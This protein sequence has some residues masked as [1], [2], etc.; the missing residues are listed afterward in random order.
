MVP[1]LLFSFALSLV[2]AARAD[3]ITLDSGAVIEGD[4]A[5]FEFGGDCQISVTD[6]PLLGAI[7]IVPCRRVQ[8][9]VRTGGAEPTKVG[10]VEPAK[11]GVVE[12]VKAVEAQPRAVVD[13]TMP[14]YAAAEPQVESG[15]VEPVAVEPAERKA[16]AFGVVAA[17]PE[18]PVAEPVAVPVAAPVAALPASPFDGDGFLA[19]RAPTALNQPRSAPSMD[20]D[21][22][23][24]DDDDQDTSTT[25][26]A[27]TDRKAVHF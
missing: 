3:S 11:V 19:P 24:D 13:T 7:V 5:R 17:E 9:S 8:S 27:T 22:D 4:L 1:S 18:A 16:V 10:V 14:A 20:Q 15:A 23:E 12:P 2:G 6:G 26:A 25:T 21:A